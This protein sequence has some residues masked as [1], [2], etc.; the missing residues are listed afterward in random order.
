MSDNRYDKSQNISEEEVDTVLKEL[1]YEKREHDIP[2]W[3]R[4]KCRLLGPHDWVSIHAYDVQT[5][6][7]WEDG[8][9]CDTCGKEIG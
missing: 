6:E 7:V 1:G 8:M 2:L 4:V 9:V 5:H 3:R